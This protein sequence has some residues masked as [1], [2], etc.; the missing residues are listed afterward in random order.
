MKPE[1]VYMHTMQYELD[2]LAKEAMSDNHRSVAISKL[3]LI[4]KFIS[5]NN[6]KKNSKNILR[7]QSSKSYL[8]SSEKSGSS[9][10]LSKNKYGNNN[11]NNLEVD[12]NETS[13]KK[14]TP[15]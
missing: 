12:K 6:S 13:E 4:S 9:E 11:N 15:L 14:L 2:L 5:K 8:P 7:S 1:D 10:Y 3:D